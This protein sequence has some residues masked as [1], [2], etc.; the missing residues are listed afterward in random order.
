[1]FE[2]FDGYRLSYVELYDGCRVSHVVSPRDS[3]ERI[4]VRTVLLNLLTYK[5]TWLKYTCGLTV[6]FL[7]FYIVAILLVVLIKLYRNSTKGAS[8]SSPC[9]HRLPFPDNYKRSN[10]I[11]TAPMHYVCIF[12]RPGQLDTDF[13][14]EIAGTVTLEACPSSSGHGDEGHTI[15][16]T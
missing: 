8:P 12:D 15:N 9:F 1:M 13:V 10:S 7:I 6:D 3:M 16:L 4:G 11:S 2:R 5:R 14:A